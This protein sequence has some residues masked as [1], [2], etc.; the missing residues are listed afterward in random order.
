MT[1]RDFLTAIWPA[2]GYYVIATKYKIPNSDKTTYIHKVYE[3]V[4]AA[5]RYI[6]QHVKSDDL[7]FA[8]HSLTEKRVWSDTKLNWQTKQPGAWQ[9]RVQSNM[10]AARAFFFDLDV[11]DEKQKYATQSE[12]L[13]ALMAFCKSAKLPKPM[14]TSSGGGLHVY[15]LV[16]NEIPSDQWK[17]HAQILKDLAK[18][19]KLKA[20]PSRTTDTASVLRVAGSFN[21]KDK[22]NPRAVRVLVSGSH[23]PNEVFLKKLSDAATRGEIST[24]IL[25]PVPQ[26][27]LGDDL[28]SNITR[29]SG[30]P[31]SMKALATACPQVRRLMR[32]GG[33]VSEPE[34]YA[35]IQLMRFVER[36][37]VL[38]HKM[39]AKYAGFKPA[40]LEEKWS[41]LESKDIGPTLCTN[42]ADKCGEDLCEGCAFNGKVVSPIS[43]AR[44]IDTAPAPVAT[45][46]NPQFPTAVEI[47]PAPKPYTRLKEGG[48]S[49]KVK[50]A[51]G[52]E[53]HVKIY[54]NDLYPISRVVNL[55]EKIEQQVW[56][57]TLPRGEVRD[58]VLDA[59]ALYDRKKFL[60]TIANHGI[61]PRASNIQHLMDY[62][63]AYIAEL[64]KLA[65]AESQENHLGWNVDRTQFVLPDKILLSDG[66]VKPVTLSLG[67]ERATSQILKRGTLERQIELLNFYKGKEYI[68]N[69]FFILGHLA[70]PLFHATGHHG[71]IVN[72][73]GDAGA[74][75][76]TTLYTGA[77]LW[78][79]PELYPI[80][81]TNDG[82]TA[83]ARN[84]RV[85]TL[86]NLPVCVDEITHM[87]VKAAQNLTMNVTQP[88]PKKDRCERTGAIQL[89][90][91]S[92]KSTIMFTTGNNSVHSMLSS[93]N[94]AGTAGSMRVFEILFKHTMVHKKYEADAYWRELKQNHGHIGERF[95]MYVVQ[96]VD[97][98]DK[99]VQQKMREVDQAAN[100]L[101]SE[102]FWSAT[103]A[104]ILVANEIA[105]DLGLLS[106]P[107]ADVYDWVMGPQIAH[108][109]GVVHDEY[110][111]PIGVLSDYLESI[112]AGVIVTDRT[113]IAGGQVP[114]LKAPQGAL[115]A[116]YDVHEQCMWVLKKNFKDYCVRDGSNMLQ[117]LDALHKDALTTNGRTTTVV[118][119]KRTKKKLGANTDYGKAVSYCFTIDMT[120]PRVTGVVDLKVVGGSKQ[121]PS[122]TT[123]TKG[124]LRSV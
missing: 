116:H 11:G 40:E 115:L 44:R 4:D 58:F 109:R 120:D 46:S 31:V 56:R 42:M 107:Q 3:T 75:K 1:P 89:E 52:D 6:S 85:A 8:V 111:T 12:A 108:M 106:Y 13:T 47:P 30:P 124:S 43:A 24:S 77:S 103:V 80:N 62:M 37:Q 123:P 57:A 104:T 10:R 36:G 55:E 9:V 83:N 110:S 38:A 50:A 59:D 117:I 26:H 29:D 27:L 72:A 105:T 35:S 121:Q 60:M 119:H 14:V 90:S 113:Q 99:R 84:E 54:E 86:A 112:N 64:Q 73:S 81:G 79:Q 22:A 19:H 101:S 95:M 23:T 98:I 45:H 48:I 100:I 20:D 15:W 34:W 102:R 87:D 76:S 70:A 32:L 21:L 33:N 92:Y 65:D 63:V 68:P 114:I 91:E 94:S 93:N 122:T 41:Q 66:T 74:S 16:E 5:V 25:P 53:I 118:G 97:A 67:A 82:S 2:S 17:Q 71:V 78:G 88:N 18:H 51:D 96:H 69:Q 7:F 28:G 61:Y 39:S 49:V